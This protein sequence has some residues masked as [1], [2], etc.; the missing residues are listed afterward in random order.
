MPSRTIHDVPGDAGASAP[1]ELPAG[2]PARPFLSA[3]EVVGRLLAST[4]ESERH[5]LLE[6][7][8]SAADLQQLFVAL[9][10]ESERHLGIAPRTAL[11]L[12]R[13]LAF[14]AGLAGNAYH[15][16][17]G[18]MAEADA[19]RV[20]G[21][22][23]E[24]VASYDA[25]GQAF[26]EQGHEVGWARTRIGWIISMHRLGRSAE[27]LGAF[28]RARE[29][30]ARAG[31][32]RRG[33]AMDL[34][35]AVVCRDLGEFQR[36][37]ELYGSAELAYASLGLA[38][39]TL[40]AKA[41]T[42]R[43]SIRLLLGDFATALADLDQARAV[44]ARHGQGL[45]VLGQDHNTAVVYL[46]QGYYTK[47]I[48]RLGQVVV[49]ADDA[50]LA[51][52][53][54]SSTRAMAE[55]YLHLN[56]NQEALE[57]GQETVARFERLAMPGDA[58]KARLL[59]AVAYER[60]GDSEPALAMLDSAEGV[61]RERALLSHLG[62]AALKRAQLQLAREEWLNAS[63]QAERAGAIFVQQGLLRWQAQAEVVRARAALALGDGVTA[64]GL[65]SSALEVMRD[66]N[67]SWLAYK[68]HHILA[69]AARVRGERRAALGHYEAAIKSIDRAQGLLASD[70]RS[71]FLDDK[72]AVYHEAIDLA[73]ELRDGARAFDYLERAKSRALVDYLARNLDVRLKAGHQADQRLVDELARLRAEHNWFYNRLHGAATGDHP[74][75]GAATAEGRLLQA[76]VRDRERRIGRLLERLT[77]EHAEPVAGAALDQGDRCRIPPVV[78]EG[79]VLLEFYLRSDGGAVFVIDSEGMQV[80]PLST[81]AARLQRLLYQWQLNLASSARALTGGESLDGRTRHAQGILGSLYRA[82]LQPMEGH[83]AR[84]RR[85]IVVP[86]GPAHAVPFHA[87]Y[88]GR[89][90]LLERL[91]VTVCPSSG[92]LRLCAGRRPAAGG[93]ALVVA[94][95]DGG[96]L[97][98]VLQEAAAVA[99]VMPGS[100]YLEGAATRAQV[101]ERAPSHG[102]VHLAAHGVARLDNPAFAHL[103]LA[104]GQLSTVDVFNLALDG[105]LVT[106]SACET[107]RTVVTGGDELIGLGRGF[108]YAGASTLVQSL[109]R[110][111]DGSTAELMKGFYGGLKAGLGKGAALRQAQQA[112]LVGGRHHPYHWAPF[113]LVG[114]SGPL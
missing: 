112:L 106:L 95:S 85:L 24:S 11:V 92:M 21:A 17:L 74:D 6:Q 105:A 50:G 107:G 28:D 4:D 1:T 67:L 59:C 12:A 9:K 27:A 36:A 83:L 51:A 34:H 10:D 70:L 60:L 93:K 91:E 33:A 68:G 111:E 109:W 57:L 87:L 37:L 96:R 84:C 42:N 44:F 104:D 31:E 25:A 66:R 80:V 77:L 63:R 102:V 20:L 40:A 69:G 7:E 76:A 5:Q 101:I 18:V 89:A 47:A 100:C 62:F 54:A 97:P 19:L 23:G 81:G 3:G 26:L 65:A 82:L 16:A 88:D 35:M 39:E 45:S 8:V 113:Q 110:V 98:S 29:V 75:G 71:T 90:Y 53:A 30:L 48:H 103:K 58:A 52:N 78:D 61:L 55:C 72:I 114:D 22:Y 43:A 38:G 73:L 13:D 46:D 14:A 79:T 41:K 108:L 56:R 86:Y 64:V 99:A 2:P 15:Q 49:A 32:V 94:Y